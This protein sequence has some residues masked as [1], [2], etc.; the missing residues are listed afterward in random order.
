MYL[1]PQMRG[2]GV[3]IPAKTWLYKLARFVTRVWVIG[4]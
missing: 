1:V 3:Q 2:L 4:L